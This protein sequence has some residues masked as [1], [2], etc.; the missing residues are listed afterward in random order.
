M[1]CLLAIITFCV[2]TV[3]SIAAPAL[4]AENKYMFRRLFCQFLCEDE[5]PVDYCETFCSQ[6]VPREDYMAEAKKREI[7]PIVYSARF[8][9]F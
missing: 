5:L 2:L 9:N 7:D 1:N 4:K 8:S 3:P 6:A